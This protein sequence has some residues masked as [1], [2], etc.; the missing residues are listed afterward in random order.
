MTRTRISSIILFFLSLPDAAESLLSVSVDSYHSNMSLSA[1]KTDVISRTRFLSTLAIM[2]IPKLSNADQIEANSSNYVVSRKIE[3]CPQAQPRKPN[4][5]IA[6]SNIKQ[7]D[8]YSP[9]WTFEISSDEAF[10]RLKGM[11]K[12]DAM[13]DLVEID[14]S[15]RYL[16]VNTPRSFNSIDTMEFLI[17]PE[18]KV[19]VFKSMEKE[20]PGVS[21]FGANRSRLEDLRKKS[22]GVFEVM[23]NGLTADSY[24]GG[25]QG[26]RN[27]FAGQLKAFYGL[28]SGE[29]FED[30]FQ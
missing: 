19:V 23:G 2:S 1:R 17:K 29:G 16:R 27:G 5:C 12:S 10:A 14:E 3:G 20:G 4:N 22:G 9:P 24:D 11:I 7:L 18:D 15:A 28:N 25:A 13:L 30:T 26:R 6:T 8:T 21:D